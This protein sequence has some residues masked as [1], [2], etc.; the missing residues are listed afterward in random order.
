MKAPVVWAHS[1][2]ELPGILRQLISDISVGENQLFT[3]IYS[4]YSPEHV[5][6]EWDSVIRI[7][8]KSVER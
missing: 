1:F 5:K 6:E 8:V 2:D 3:P 7:C 4:L